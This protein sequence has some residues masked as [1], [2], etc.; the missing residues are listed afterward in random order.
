MPTVES[1]DAI[2]LVAKHAQEAVEQGQRVLFY[3][4]PIPEAHSPIPSVSRVIEVIEGEGWIL[5][6][7]DL[8]TTKDG[9]F[10]FRRV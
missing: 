3:Y 6:R 1:T 10:L 9:Y 8:A 4:L 7:M 2:D 5:E